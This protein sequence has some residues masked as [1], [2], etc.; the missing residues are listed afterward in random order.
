[1]LNALLVLAFLLVGQDPQQTGVVAGS[2]VPP[3][4]AQVILLG[5][6]YAD[7]WATEVQKRLDVYWQQ[8]QTVLA[9]RKEV[10]SQ[11]SR[12]AH[13]DAASIIVTRMRNELPGKASDYVLETSADG[14]FEFRNLPF[15]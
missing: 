11:L 1:M 13:K 9:S 15:G 10:F 12:Q 14:K 3:Q 4:S 5:P 7:L 6:D 8:Y 2:V